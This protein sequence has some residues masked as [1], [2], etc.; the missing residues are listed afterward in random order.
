MRRSTTI[1]ILIFA[2]LHWSLPANAYTF[3]Y[4]NSV[5]TIQIKWPTPTI[6]IAFSTSLRQTPPNIKAGSDVLG[7]ARHAL[8]NWSQNSNIRFIETTSNA[9]SISA[10]GNGDQVS[11]ITVANTPENAAAFPPCDSAE[12][13]KTG[14]TRVFYNPKT[15]EITEADIAINPCLQFSTDSSPGTY[16]LEATLTHELGHL[17]GLEHSSVIG[18]TMQPRQGQNGLYNLPAL[19][20]RTL[21][22]D[23]RAGVHALYSPQGGLG[24]IAGSVRVGTSLNGAHVWAENIDTRQVIASSIASTETFRI[25]NLPPGHYRVVAESL[26]APISASEITS[27]R[28]PDDELMP[29]TLSRTSELASHVT[30]TAETTTTLS[31]SSADSHAPTINPRLFGI[32]SQLSTIPVPLTPGK[33][34]KLYVGGEGLD[35]VQAQGV[36]VTSPYFKINPATFMQQDFGIG[37]PVITFDVVVAPDAPAGD[38]SLRL[39]GKNNEIAYLSSALTIDRPVEA[40]TP[41]PIDD[42]QLFVRPQSLARLQRAPDVSCYQFWLDVLNNCVC[43]NYLA[44]TCQVISPAET[45]QNFSHALKN[46]IADCPTLT[47]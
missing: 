19:T 8:S 15:G 41:V 7:A 10:P 11:L 1:L 22:D 28:S 27:T 39:V 5:A 40:P 35:K 23:D 34:Y 18:A 44:M 33:T 20:P 16:D 17:L 13:I 26:D 12:Q 31:I 9:Q 32:N 30:V 43:K 4:A 21:S 45:Q 37:I 14:R 24:A 42:A 6:T 2:L 25:D 46:S 36:R 47:P 3:Q 29:T 38:Y